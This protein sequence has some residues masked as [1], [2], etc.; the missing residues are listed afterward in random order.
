MRTVGCKDIAEDPKLLHKTLGLFETIEQ[1]STPAAIILP[2][3]PT[4]AL[5]KRTIAGGRLYM[6]FKKIVDDRRKTGKRE[7]DP[8][9]H[10]IDQNDSINEIIQVRSP[11]KMTGRPTDDLVVRCGRTLRGAAK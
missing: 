5:I 2:R 11:S 8:L 1:S 3:F 10:L 7:D 4:L 6:I 9:Q